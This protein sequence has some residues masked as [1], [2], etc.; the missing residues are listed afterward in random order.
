VPRIRI[1]LEHYPL[2]EPEP[3]IYPLLI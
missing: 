2:V 1:Y 3:E